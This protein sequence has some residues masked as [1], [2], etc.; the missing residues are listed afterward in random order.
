MKITPAFSS[1]LRHLLTVVSLGAHSGEVGRGIWS[2][3]A[4]HSD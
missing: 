1:V 2:K 3:P 4:T